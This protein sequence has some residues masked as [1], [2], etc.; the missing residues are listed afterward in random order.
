MNFTIEG[1]KTRLSSIGSQPK[2]VVF[3]V[4]VDVDVVFV[5]VIVLD[6]V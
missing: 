6:I 2:Q 4:V 1:R 5:V 3:V